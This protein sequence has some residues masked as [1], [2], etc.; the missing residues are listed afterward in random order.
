MHFPA[1]KSINVKVI[2]RNRRNT[3]I[4]VKSTDLYQSKAYIR[5]TKT[6]LR[7]N[8]LRAE[9]KDLFSVNL[10]Y[11]FGGGR[12][13]DIEREVGKQEW[14]GEVHFVNILALF[15]ITKYFT[16]RFFLN[17]MLNIFFNIFHIQ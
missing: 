3:G 9:L 10:S 14:S 4:Q 13:R 15:K 17:Q 2:L 6:K 16:F 7:N 12:V 5:T 8:S 11:W 1:V